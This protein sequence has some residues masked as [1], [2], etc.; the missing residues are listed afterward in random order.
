MPPTTGPRAMDSPDTPSQTPIAL[1]RSFGALNTF[2][3]MPSAAGLSMLPPTP[4]STRKAMS[5]DSDGA[6]L[7]SHD[8]SVNKLRPTWKMV[9]RPILSATAPENISRLAST[10]V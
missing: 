8:P 1:A 10:I 9:R 5:Q 7:H 3:M 6:R 4:C 2:V